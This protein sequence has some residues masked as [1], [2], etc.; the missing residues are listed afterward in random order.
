MLWD[1]VGC[2]DAVM[3]LDA[4]M[5]RLTPELCGGWEQ[6][7]YNVTMAAGRPGI[8][9]RHWELLMSRYAVQRGG[10]SLS[11]GIDPGTRIKHAGAPGRT[12]QCDVGAGT[13]AP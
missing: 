11:G 1:A 10:S 13:P 3:L 12:G 2:S 6:C 9:T 4:A 7:E 5:Y 8:V